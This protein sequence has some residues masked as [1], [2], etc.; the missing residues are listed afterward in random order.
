MPIKALMVD[1]DGV[2]VVQP[3][4]NGWATN[5]ERDLGVSQARLQ[6]SFFTPHFTD[7]VTGR[8]ALRDRLAPVLAEIAPAV[9][10]DV[11][12]GYWFGN[13]AHLD[14]GLLAQIDDMRAK[15]MRVEL[16]TVQEHERAA[17]LWTTLGLKNH[18]DAINYAADLGVTKPSPEFFHAI[19]ARCG[20]ASDDIF[21]IDDKA[22]NVDAARALGWHAAV[23][24]GNRTVL[25]LMT[26]AGVA[27]AV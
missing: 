7:I 22:T 2:V 25:D 18:F 19:E 1:V 16:A 23:W 13:D 15:G 26:E 10:C 20:L 5:L 12:I 6:E 27:L 14:Q 21:F 24:D 8:A 4:L 3:Q 17:Y 9:S 11:F